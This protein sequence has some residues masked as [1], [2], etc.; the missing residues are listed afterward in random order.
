MDRFLVDGPVRAPRTLVLAHGAGAPMDSPFMNAVAGGT[1]KQGFR[2]L[3][4]EFPYMRARRDEGRRKPPDREPVLRA[5]WLEAIAEAAGKKGASSVAIGGK[6]MGGR[7][8][9]MVADEAGVAGLV[10][11]GYPF[12]PPA[13]PEKLRVAHLERLKTLTLI[14]Q[15]ERDAFGT[16]EEVPRYPLSKAIRILFIPDGDHS[17]KPRVSSGRTEEQNLREAIAEVA[18]FLGTLPG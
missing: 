15:G 1:A 4:F 13:R 10:C 17:F 7:I 2:V 6:S 11:L 5:S 16:R 3:R 12:H 8:A 18:A 14:V 9:S